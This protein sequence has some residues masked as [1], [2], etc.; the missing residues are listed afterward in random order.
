MLIILS[1]NAWTRSSEPQQP[2]SQALEQQRPFQV[3]NELDQR[4]TR[5]NPLVVDSMRGPEDIADKQL[6]KQQRIEELGSSRSSLYIN[7]GLLLIALLQAWLFVWQLR[8]MRHSLRDT[9]IAARAAE[10]SAD[11]AEKAMVWSQR[12]YIRVDVERIEFSPTKAIEIVLRISND[13]QTPAY[14]ST[15]YSWAD[16]R[17]FP[18]PPEGVFTGTQGNQPNAESVIHPKAAVRNKTGTLPL[19]QETFDAIAA[20]DTLRLYIFG[21]TKYKD[22]FGY[23]RLTNFCFATRVAPGVKADTAYCHLHNEAT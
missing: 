8:I 2:A 7:S 3:K 15:T 6:E 4:G 21:H 20:G 19:P 14:L 17:A 10:R 18:H 23:D 12:A 13:G 1:A 16:V 9:E 11:I 5:Q 22:A